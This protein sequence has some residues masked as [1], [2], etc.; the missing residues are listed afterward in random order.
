MTGE[1]D[2]T[3]TPAAAR[4]D[5]GRL[6]ERGVRHEVVTFPGGHELD[7]AALAEVAARVRA[8]ARDGVGP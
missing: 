5:A 6:A 8:L 2:L 1:R 3:F 4:A 7:A